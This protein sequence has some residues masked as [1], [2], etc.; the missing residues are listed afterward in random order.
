MFLHKYIA[1]CLGRAIS[2]ERLEPFKSLTVI[3]KYFATVS[4]IKSY[5]STFSLFVT[6]SLIALSAISIVIG[7]WVKEDVA[8][9][10]FKVPSNSLILESI[11]VAILDNM[12][13]SI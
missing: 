1:I 2:F 5:E 12:S 6:T 10:L 3:L 7:A 8:I 13:S 4:W 11:F 9:N